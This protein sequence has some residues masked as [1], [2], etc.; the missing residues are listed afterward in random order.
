MKNFS[1]YI[2][3]SFQVYGS[4]YIAKIHLTLVVFLLW[5]LSGMSFLYVSVKPSLYENI[6]FFC[7]RV[8]FVGEGTRSKMFKKRHFFIGSKNFRPGILES[9]GFPRENREYLENL[10]SDYVILIL[11]RWLLRVDLPYK[12]N[13][14]HTLAHYEEH[15]SR[16]IIVWT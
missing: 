1:V 2:P 9:I 13:A 5:V 3:F 10:L 7:F 16:L 12:E 15:D 6:T 11:W 8:V 4:F 14:H